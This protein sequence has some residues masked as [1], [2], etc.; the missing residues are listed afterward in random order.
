M[1]VCVCVTTAEADVLCTRMAEK[2]NN[3]ME[4]RMIK[5]QRLVLL[6]SVEVGNETVMFKYVSKRSLH[7]AKKTDKNKEK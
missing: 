6:A 7:C 1:C 5:D 3:K 2:I 4:H